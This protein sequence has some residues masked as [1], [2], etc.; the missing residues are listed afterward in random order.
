MFR[1]VPFALSASITVSRIPHTTK[2][3][4]LN[5]VCIAQ[6]GM[7]LASRVEVFTELSCRQLHYNYNHTSTPDVRGIYASVHPQVDA[8]SNFTSLY[9]HSILPPAQPS[10]GESEGDGVSEGD[11]PRVIPGKKCVSDPAVQAGAARFQTIVTT[12]MG[13]LSALTTGWWGQFGER[14]GRTRV[15]AISTFGLFLT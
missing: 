5:L 7:T 11:D 8:S 13:A 15:L 14:H 2:V 12:T 4:R 1:L 6:R 9:L 10:L 3:L